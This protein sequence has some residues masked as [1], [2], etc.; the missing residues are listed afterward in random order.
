MKRLAALL[1]AIVG[2][3]TTPVHAQDWE[4]DAALYGWMCGLE[5]TVGFTDALQ[6]PFDASFE[7]LL[8]YVDFAMA[9]HFEAKNPRAVL[10]TDIAYFNLG[11]TRDATVIRTPVTINMD[12]Q[13][14]IFE[15]GGGYRVRPDVDLILAGRYYV[16]QSGLTT[17]S[18]RG[19]TDIPGLNEWGDIY[20]GV[21]FTR[22]YAENWMFSIRGDIGAGGSKF[23]WFG[24]AL[25]AY[26]F[27]QTISAGLGYRI[28]SLDHEPDI[29]EGEYFLYDVT[30][31]GFGLGVGFRF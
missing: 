3:T 10:I 26:R 1:A 2:L 31:N 21:R 11:A 25:V 16:F 23:A 4:Y 18:E 17:N 15:L 24:N 8:D 5:G 7:E 22:D 29:D 28:L 19:T 20:A 14:W 27:N 12:L 9:G 6:R 13:E 30:Q